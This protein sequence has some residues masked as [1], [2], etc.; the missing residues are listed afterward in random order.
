MKMVLQTVTDVGG[1]GM[2]E[3]LGGGGTDDDLV[4]ELGGGGTV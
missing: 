4:D 2:V 3:E 1:H